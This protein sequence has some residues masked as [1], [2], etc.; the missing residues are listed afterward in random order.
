MIGAKNVAN[1][2]AH[3]FHTSCTLKTAVLCSHKTMGGTRGNT[4]APRHHGRRIRDYVRAELATE[5][6]SNLLTLF[7]LLQSA[8]LLYQ[9]VFLQSFYLRDLRSPVTMLC[10]L[11]AWAAEE[12]PMQQCMLIRE[13]NVVLGPMRCWIINSALSFHPLSM[14][15]NFLE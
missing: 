13:E 4:E 15:F 10:G 7:I 3:S 2:F 8:L 6:M 12:Y 14:M 9:V 1:H 5:L 11:V